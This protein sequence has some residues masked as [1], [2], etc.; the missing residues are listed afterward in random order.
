MIDTFIYNC[1]KI[2]S[3]I[4][5]YYLWLDRIHLYQ[6]LERPKRKFSIS[7]KVGWALIRP[8]KKNE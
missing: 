5:V 8:L 2:A 3:L 7:T 4:L 6:T 1:N